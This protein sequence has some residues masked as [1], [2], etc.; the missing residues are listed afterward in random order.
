[1]RR[2][3]RRVASISSAAGRSRTSG[4]SAGSSAFSAIAAWFVVK[5]RIG[6]SIA[7]TSA[8]TAIV[9]IIQ[10]IQRR[11]RRI[12]T[13]AK[14]PTAIWGV[15]A[16]RCKPSGPGGGLRAIAAYFMPMLTPRTWTVALI[17]LGVAGASLEPRGHDPGDS[18]QADERRAL[19]TETRPM[20]TR[21]LAASAI[22]LF[23]IGCAARLAPPEPDEVRTE[24]AR[25]DDTAAAIDDLRGMA[26]P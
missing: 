6:S 17:V 23:S 4:L 11:L 25:E 14:S 10:G 13:M 8:S 26:H 20:R 24:S 9:A 19:A 12:L 21:C 18:R 3:A 5:S 16:P 2:A 22:L 15:G 1:M 7:T